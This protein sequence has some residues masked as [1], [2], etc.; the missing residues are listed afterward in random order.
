MNLLFIF[1]FYDL[2][3]EWYIFLSGKPAP[4]VTWWRDRTLIDR[5]YFLTKRGFARNRL[6]LSK[7]ERG[8]LMAELICL[9]ANTNLTIP[10]MTRVI[11]DMNRK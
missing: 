6:A 10:K 3:H 8:D 5:H 2:N 1:T 4:Q 9:A 11:L 7:I